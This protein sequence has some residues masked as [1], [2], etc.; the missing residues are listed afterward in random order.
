MYPLQTSVASGL[1][2]SAN[3]LLPYAI[4]NV[5]LVPFCELRIDEMVDVKE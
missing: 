5:M 4:Y 2:L 1:V 3:V